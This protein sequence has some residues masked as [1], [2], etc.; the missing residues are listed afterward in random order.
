[1]A[2]CVQER[3]EVEWTQGQHLTAMQRRYLVSQAGA[4]HSGPRLAL[5]AHQS[6]LIVVEVELYNLALPLLHE[7]LWVVPQAEGAPPRVSLWMQMVCAEKALLHSGP[8]ATAVP[9]HAHAQE[10]LH[11]FQMTNLSDANQ[12]VHHVHKVPLSAPTRVAHDWEVA[13]HAQM[14]LQP[15]EGKDMPLHA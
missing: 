4:A 2:P 6:I 1:M 10:P 5:G 8:H 13:P 15:K 3:V 14:A 7:G 11:Y 9:P 12:Q